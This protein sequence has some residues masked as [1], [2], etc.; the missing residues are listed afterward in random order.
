MR[1]AL[2]RPKRISR[3]DME[4]FA[5]VESPKKAVEHIVHWH[6]ERKRSAAKS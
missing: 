6:A 2:V 5:C 1:E 3:E 4:L